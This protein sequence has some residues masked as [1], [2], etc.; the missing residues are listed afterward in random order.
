MC[1]DSDSG[2][3]SVKD[4]DYDNQK[5]GKGGKLR[6]YELRLTR[7][8]L[9]FRKQF[10][11][12]FSWGGGDRRKRGEGRGR[13]FPLSWQHCER[14][15]MPNRPAWQGLTN[16]NFEIIDRNRKIAKFKSCPSH[17]KILPMIGNHF[18]RTVSLILSKFA[19]FQ[20]INTNLTTYYLFILLQNVE[21]HCCLIDQI[22]LT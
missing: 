3:K 12:F 1:K 14:R 2:N 18:N 21:T 10:Y 17:I 20:F 6:K 19:K 5:D 9:L 13:L 22:S 7:R 11:N 15:D 8:N 16:L 4:S